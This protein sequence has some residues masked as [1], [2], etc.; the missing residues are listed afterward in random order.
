MDPPTAQNGVT[1]WPHLS[2]QARFLM[3]IFFGSRESTPSECSIWCL[4]SDART[5]VPSC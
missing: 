3:S 1:S 4:S 2:A 5:S